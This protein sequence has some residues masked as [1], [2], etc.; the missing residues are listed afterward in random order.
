VLQTA[1]TDAVYRTTLCEALS[2]S[3]PWQVEL[4]DRP[5]LAR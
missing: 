3:G 5:D 1:I 4:S 2:E